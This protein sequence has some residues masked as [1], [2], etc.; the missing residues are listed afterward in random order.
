L[1]S[2]PYFRPPIDDFPVEEIIK[3]CYIVGKLVQDH[4]SSYQ[5]NQQNVLTMIDFSAAVTNLRSALMVN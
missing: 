5:N 4:F 2:P 3:G 1:Q